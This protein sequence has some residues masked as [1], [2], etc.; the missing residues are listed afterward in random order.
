MIFLKFSLIVIELLLKLT[1]A[2][3]IVLFINVLDFI[4]SMHCCLEVT[5]LITIIKIFIAEWFRDFRIIK[6][7]LHFNQVVIGLISFN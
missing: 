2:N 6:I 4:G 1:M 7:L 5:F 3:A